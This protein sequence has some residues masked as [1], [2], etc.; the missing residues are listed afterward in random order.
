[1]KL[2]ALNGQSTLRTLFTVV[3]LLLTILLTVTGWTLIDRNRAWDKIS[4]NAEELKATR[5][6]NDV[7]W[8]AIE[9]QLDAI[10]R[11]VDRIQDY[12]ERGGR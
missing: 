2:D 7:R 3:G 5:A 9:K 11:G 1:M 10:Q 12:H 6:E 8:D 4:S